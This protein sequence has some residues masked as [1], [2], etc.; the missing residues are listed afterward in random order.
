MK[1]L[2]VN[3]VI[4]P[5]VLDRQTLNKINMD[6]FINTNKDSKKVLKVFEKLIVFY[7]HCFLDLI[8]GRRAVLY[9]NITYG[10][11]RPSCLALTLG[12][13]VFEL[14]YRRL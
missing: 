5:Q 10:S 7:V 9:E 14:C 4:L 12:S 13:L 1:L 11:W 2:K 3:L 8:F 6:W